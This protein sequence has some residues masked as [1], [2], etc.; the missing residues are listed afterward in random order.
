MKAPRSWQHIVRIDIGMIFLKSG[1]R[2]GASRSVS[3]KDRNINDKY[4]HMQKSLTEFDPIA[5]PPAGR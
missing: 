3:T 5:G 2:T 1:E 4:S